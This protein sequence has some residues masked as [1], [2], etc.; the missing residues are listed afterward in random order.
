YTPGARSRNISVVAAVS[1]R[2]VLYH[3]IRNTAFNGESF[4]SSLIELNTVCLDKGILNPVFILDNCRIHHYLGLKETIES[5][6]LTLLYLPPYSP[7]LNPIENVFSV[8]KNAVIRTGCKNEEELYSVIS[9][10]FLEIEPSVCEAFYR[11]MLRYLNKSA[12]REIIN[13]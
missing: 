3:K 13:E 5:L 1:K 12:N 7:F 10:T 9:S 4:K 2:G 6:N 11:K 8:W